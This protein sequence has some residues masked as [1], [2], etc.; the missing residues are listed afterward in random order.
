MDFRQAF[1]PIFLLERR[2]LAVSIALALVAVFLAWSFTRRIIRP[3]QLLEDSDRA[4][5]RGDKAAAIIPEEGLPDDELGALVRTRN[6]RVRA[7]A[8]ASAA[9]KDRTAELRDA[10][11]ELEHM[12]YSIIHEM[13]AP[14]RAMTGFIQVVLH[15]EGQAL[16]QDSRDNLQRV[17]AAAARMDRLICDVLN[18]S[19]LAR[20]QLPI[21]RVNTSELLR[22]ILETYPSLQDAK[23]LFPP[24]LPDV[25]GNEALLTQC[26]SNLLA[27]A[28]KFAQPGSRPEVEITAERNDGRVRIALKD[29]GVGIPQSM[30]ARI[31]RL[32]Q[33]GNQ[34]GENTG[35]GLAIVRKA[36]ERMGGQ[37]GVS[38]EPGR[39][40]LFWIELPAA[41]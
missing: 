23:I 11:A 35:V 19:Q 33:R 38:S 8:D 31:F 2:F 40:S 4:F 7:L 10:A 6:A 13:R 25:Q 26:F 30:Q 24:A 22:G 12:S 20:G 39:G 36:V 16:R 27:N 3:I 29:N 1:A 9:L 14:L 34:A 5:L 17:K 21:H 28:V 41:V 15:E 37:V 18:Y 32:F